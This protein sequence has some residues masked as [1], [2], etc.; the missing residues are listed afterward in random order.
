MQ[1]KIFNI[2]ALY[3]TP[4]IVIFALYIQINGSD[5]PG[6]GFQAG[7]ILAS[8]LILHNLMYGNRILGIINFHFLK[9]LA[10]SGIILYI[11]TGILCMYKGGNFLDYSA[12]KFDSAYQLSAQKIGVTIIEWGIAVTV[13]STLCLI[14][15]SFVTRDALLS[16]D[17]D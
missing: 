13:F 3:S 10:V 8:V 5:E 7:A 6:G 2:I 4:Y 11:G 16:H 1:N 15:F 12:L 9:K 14:Y 17:I